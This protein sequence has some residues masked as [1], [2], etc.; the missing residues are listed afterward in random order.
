MTTIVVIMSHKVWLKSRV[1]GKQTNWR[2]DDNCR[3]FE[4][5]VEGY[6]RGCDVETWHINMYHIHL[7]HKHPS[8]WN[9]VCSTLKLCA[10][11]ITV[12]TWNY[13][14]S[15]S[16]HTKSGNPVFIQHVSL[17]IIVVMLFMNF[18]SKNRFSCMDGDFYP[19]S[20]CHNVRIFGF[21]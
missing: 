7:T 13:Q 14:F 17:E 10:I 12:I 19:D 3:Q 18:F 5:S 8:Q 15:S 2:N 11:S 21:L 20:F 1:E 16:P 9:C 4:M 6:K